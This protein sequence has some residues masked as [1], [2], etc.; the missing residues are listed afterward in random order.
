MNKEYKTEADLCDEFIKN[1]SDEWISYPE[2]NDY[3]IFLVHKETGAQIGIEAKLFLNTKVLTQVLPSS[4]CEYY[5]VKGPDFLAVLVPKIK[6]N[7]VEKLCRHLGVTVIEMNRFTSCGFSPD[8]PSFSDQ[9]ERWYGFSDDWF[10][11]CQI[12]RLD[13]PIVVPKV[14]CGVPSPKKLTDWKIKSI[15]LLIILE[16]FGYVTRKDFKDLKLNPSLWT[17]S[18]WLHPSTKK[19]RWEKCDATPDL[20]YQ[21]PE[22]YEEIEHLFDSW[23]V[24]IENRKQTND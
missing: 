10:D 13:V 16:K 24:E 12:D 14:K 23:F 2:T 11:R 6:R 3:D 19:G 8:L 1:I 20:K 18:R 15:K 9:Y 17:S 22:N 21:H 5:N 7:D 4:N